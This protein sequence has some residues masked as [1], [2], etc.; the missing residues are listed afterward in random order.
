MT[1]M[2]AAEFGKMSVHGIIFQK[3]PL[4]IV[5][6]VKKQNITI[7]S[8]YENRVLTNTLTAKNEE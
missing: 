8:A 6:A 7:L 5:T 2:K 4:F 3:T 1:V